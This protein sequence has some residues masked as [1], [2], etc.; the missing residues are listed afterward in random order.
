MRN[1]AVGKPPSFHDAAARASAVF[2]HHHDAFGG[3]VRWDRHRRLCP[4]QTG[5]EQQHQHGAAPN[6]SLP[7]RPDHG[8]Y[9]LVGTKRGREH[10]FAEPSSRPLDCLRVLIHHNGQ[11]H[12]CLSAIPTVRISPRLTILT[13]I[14]RRAG[15]CLPSCFFLPKYH[16]GAL[17]LSVSI[18]PPLNRP[19]EPKRLAACREGATGELTAGWRVSFPNSV[20]ERDSM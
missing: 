17:R 1:P 20:L 10:R 7:V 19:A 3:V 16:K 14:G 2:M 12:H 15:P 18:K 9:L 8:T 4:C 13:R 6:G 5:P 11:F